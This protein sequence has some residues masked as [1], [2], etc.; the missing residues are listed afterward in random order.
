M[1]RPIAQENTPGA[2]SNNPADA[3]ATALGLGEP[4]G[5]PAQGATTPGAGGE[6][7]V[8]Q[9]GVTQEPAPTGQPGTW[10]DVDRLFPEVAKKFQGDPVKIAQS[11]TELERAFHGFRELGLS[12]DQALQAIQ[13]QVAETEAAET[14]EGDGTAA[15]VS[16]DE[17]LKELAASPR[18]AILKV[19][20]QALDKGLAPM[21]ESTATMQATGMWEAAKKAYPDIVTYEGTMSEILTTIPELAKLPNVVETVYWLAKLSPQHREGTINALRLEGRN[22]VLEQV[23]GGT[24]EP[25]SGGGAPPMKQADPAQKVVEEILAVGPQRPKLVPMT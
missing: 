15:E 23:R 21:R 13:Q 24:V 10:E 17:F 20:D 4:T 6:G 19:V 18:A 8:S 16:E 22:T 11:Y 9:G 25:G 2:A 3:G 5:A 7:A 14:G 1:E 12:P